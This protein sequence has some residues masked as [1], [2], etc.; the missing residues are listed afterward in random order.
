MI[1]PRICFFL[2]STFLLALCPDPFTPTGELTESEEGGVIHTLEVLD[3]EDRTVIANTWTRKL[4]GEF[5]CNGVVTLGNPDAKPSSGLA[6]DWGATIQ[7]PFFPEQFADLS[8]ELM[9]RPAEVCSEGRT[10]RLYF[11]RGLDG[12]EYRS[13]VWSFIAWAASP[14]D[15]NGDGLVNGKDLTLLLADWGDADDSPA[16]LDRDGAVGP[17][18][19]EIL[20]GAWG[21]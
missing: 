16:D 13:A 3:E 7:L 9:G 4:K 2:V 11:S 15:L 12:A 20:L 1:I 8:G 18:D 19:L 17:A 14:G 10:V 5:R 21:T 6:L